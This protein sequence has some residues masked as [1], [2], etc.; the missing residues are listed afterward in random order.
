[1]LMMVLLHRVRDPFLVHRQAHASTVADV[2]ERRPY[3]RLIQSVVKCIPSSS[4]TVFLWSRSLIDFDTS[5]FLILV[6][7]ISDSL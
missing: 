7:R 5:T 1:M 4:E 3:A 6:V 2:P